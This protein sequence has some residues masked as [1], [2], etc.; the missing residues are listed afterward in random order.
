MT[1]E[2]RGQSIGF[3][4]AANPKYATRSGDERAASSVGNHWFSFR[5]NFFQM[6]AAAR[7][8]QNPERPIGHTFGRNRK[9]R[10]SSDH[11][12]WAIPVRNGATNAIGPGAEWQRGQS[13]DEHNSA[14][15]TLLQTRVPAEN[16]QSLGIGKRNSQLA[17]WNSRCKFNFKP[18]SDC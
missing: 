12:G 14:G 17:V 3:N 9:L 1:T 10:R 8:T 2:I 7:Q 16:N 6:K 5:S 13:Q 18:N 4:L 11:R 15:S